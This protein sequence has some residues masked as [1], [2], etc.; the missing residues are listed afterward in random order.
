MDITE[1]HLR[2]IYRKG[3]LLVDGTQTKILDKVY[4]VIEMKIEPGKC[5]AYET[6]YLFIYFEGKISIWGNFNSISR[7]KSCVS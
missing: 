3:D 6:I 2:V 1:R 5:E 4:C 7:G